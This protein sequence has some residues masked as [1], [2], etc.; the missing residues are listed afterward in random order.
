MFP[1]YAYM[2]MFATKGLHISM[3]VFLEYPSD[4]SCIL[5]VLMTTNHVVETN[6][7]HDKY[8][9]TIKQTTTTHNDKQAFLLVSEARM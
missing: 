1:M 4:K 6:G 5:L 2:N 9:Q 8:E 7:R 3:N